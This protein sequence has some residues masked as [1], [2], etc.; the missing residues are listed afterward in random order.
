MKLIKL[1]N[2]SQST[3]KKLES[4]LFKKSN[5]LKKLK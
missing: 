3:Y 2:V 5:F 4:K 1:K